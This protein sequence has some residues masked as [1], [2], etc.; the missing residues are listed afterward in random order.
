[1]LGG[2]GIYVWPLEMVQQDYH[3]PD[4]TRIVGLSVWMW[5]FYLL[6]S[7]QAE[8]LGHEGV[9][10]EKVHAERQ[11]GRRVHRRHRLTS[12]FHLGD[13]NHHRYEAPFII[14]P[15]GVFL[16]PD[17]QTGLCSAPNGTKRG[18]DVTQWSAAC[19]KMWG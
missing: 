10:L 9:F 6:W 19:Y 5:H 13:L 16:V 8:L 7:N 12:Q 15:L 1:M 4:K 11:R 14:T 2:G 18:G 17:D 3:S